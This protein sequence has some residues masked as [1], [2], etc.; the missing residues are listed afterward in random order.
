MEVPPML[1][2][3]EL[4]LLLL[5]PLVFGVPIAVIVLLVLVYIKSRQQGNQLHRLE[6]MIRDELTALRD[7][8]AR[9]K[10]SAAPDAPLPTSPSAPPPLPAAPL[11]AATYE[12]AGFEPDRRRQVAAAVG[13][14]SPAAASAA[15]PP[16]A[17][18]AATSPA[19][20]PAARNPGRFEQTARQILGRM[21]SWIVVGE[22][23]RSPDVAIEYA[24][25]T[26][27][28]V[29]LGITI[30]VV[31]VGFFLRYAVD[32]GLL[33]PMARIALG[34]VT[35]AVLVAVGT[36][37][38]RG[39]YDLFGQ[40]LVGG[41]LAILYFSIF[42]AFGFYQYIALV[43]AFLLM[44]VVT[45]SAGVLA[46]R[47]NS[48][49]IALLGIIGGYGTPLLLQSPEPNLP[50]L[51]AY[52]LLLGIGVL[53]IGYWKNWRLLQYL[54]LACSYGW[55]LVV[56]QTIYRPADFWGVMPFLAGLFVLFSTMTFLHHIARR[57]QST[58]L[59]IMALLVNALVFFAL[60]QG[61]ILDAYTPQ[62]RAALTLALTTFYIG[63][64]YYLL[65][66]QHRD[67]ALLLTFM[68]LASLFL[69][70]TVPILLSGE[71]ITPVWAVQALLMLWLAQ[72][73]ESSF[74]R[75]LA[76][77]IYAITLWRFVFLDLRLQYAGAV[78]AAASTAPFGQYMRELLERLVM[79][80]VP[81]GS[82]AGA[83]YL[84]RRL[85]AA[86]AQATTAR[87][88]DTRSW[89]PRQQ[90]MTV[91]FTIG[92]AMLF[93]FLHLEFNRSFGTLY[94]PIRL[95]MLTA[96][97]VA[98]GIVL[99]HCHVRTQ[100]R[101][102]YVLL[103]ICVGTIL[104]KLLLIDLHSWSVG[105]FGAG[106]AVIPL[107]T[108]AYS[109]VHGGMRLLDFALIIGF[110]IYAAQLLRCW[111]EP[112]KRQLVTATALR[113]LALALLFIFTTIETNTVLA[114]YVPGLRSGGIS[115]V[116]SIFALGLVIAGIRN[117]Q[118]RWRYMGLAL[119]AVVVWRI[120]LIDLRQL[121][122][123]YRIVAFIVLGIV[124][125]SASLA[126]L[127]C[128]Q[129]FTR[130]NGSSESETKAPTL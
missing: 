81:I 77:V 94:P 45:L 43:P 6:S 89:L 114:A 100:A 108:G 117:A 41:G 107:Y 90:L 15:P 92:A 73:L 104:G 20:P 116:W 27:W 49:L 112:D 105:A 72:K 13:N 46:V 11:A 82:I 78:A 57:Q 10:A 12:C 8:L 126:Y 79:A 123:I 36:R 80:G 64:V 115:I 52:L 83:G 85:P 60:G 74:L 30:I 3:E 26:T 70:L 97:W 34:L 111:T 71:W 40:G 5:I 51:F 38:L 42:A 113:W 86:F 50:G 99:A 39:T 56:V 103:V 125:L 129:V 9:D 118:A 58:L 69:T 37:L 29:R 48:L 28:L 102:L 22:E 4:M 21:W 109:L 124:V 119:F 17:P 95:P 122:Q 54:S 47:F 121:S 88:N 127:S 1:G 31:G 19:L 67:K 66:R 98:L 75:N 33:P 7:H 110:A 44:A 96:L 76:C 91:L 130:A 55:A 87:A 61:L 2:M 18:T 14:T 35:G 120:F 23:H 25:A 63:H 59:E 24:I 16:A 93:V 101:W 62:W 65:A 84:L 106:T 128:R 68:A 53:A 32:E